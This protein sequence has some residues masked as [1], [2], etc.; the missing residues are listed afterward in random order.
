MS[1]ADVVDAAEEPDV[2]VEEPEESPV[3]QEQGDAPPAGRKRLSGVALAEK[4]L[5]QAETEA[6]KA[7]KRV[8][9]CQEKAKG[10]GPESKRTT[11]L[12]K[13]QIN[14]FKEW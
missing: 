13:A 10:S 11:D 6:E 4:K 1:D 9:D 8:E 5:H 2:A 3:D 7:Q 12:N 14:L